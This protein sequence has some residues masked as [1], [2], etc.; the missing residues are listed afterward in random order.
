MISAY[1]LGKCNFR[2]REL[3][4]Y[5][6]DAKRSV[7]TG[8]TVCTL[9]AKNWSISRMFA[10]KIIRAKRRPAKCNKE[11]KYGLIMQCLDHLVQSYQMHYAGATYFTIRTVFTLSLIHI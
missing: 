8:S 9:C 6:R 1:F 4:E 11:L 7:Q 2:H 3:G 10:V 5:G